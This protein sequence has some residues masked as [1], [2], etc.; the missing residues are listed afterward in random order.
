MNFTVVDKNAEDML[1]ALLLAEEHKMSGKGVKIPDMKFLQCQFF[2]IAMTASLAD[3]RDFLDGISAADECALY[4]CN[5]GDLIIKWSGGSRDLRDKIVH[6][7]TEKF[8]DAIRKYMSPEDFFVD[9]DLLDGRQKLKA[10]CA[11]KLKKQTKN[12]Q[13]LASYFSNEGLIATLRRTIQLIKM[14]RALRAK[15]VMMIV[16][17]Q[18]FSQKILSSILK[19]YT[20]VIAG[21]SAEALIIYMEKCPDMVFLD[22]DLPDLNGHSFAKLLSD[23][24]DES[25]VVIVSGNQYEEDIQ[26]AR[27]NN[28]K[29]FIVKPYE[30]TSILKMV[31]QYKKNRN[32]N[33]A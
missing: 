31:E 1:Y 25:Y 4:F 30:K 17:D 16:E 14:Q 28:V 9:Y 33:A 19:E 12:A 6:S 27:Q 26:A 32:R 21:S 13:K 18:I 24:D 23:I 3:V 29:G 22:I 20:C 5:D 8:G 15:P 10:E 7:I 11:R 2:H